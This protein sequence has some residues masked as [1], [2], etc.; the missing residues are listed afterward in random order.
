MLQQG[1]PGRGRL[2]AGPSAHQQGSAEGQF[3][4]ADAGRGRSQ[5]QVRPLR[6][7]RDAAG[8][9]DVPEQV[10]VRKIEAHWGYLLILR[11]QTT[12]KGYCNGLFSGSS[13]VNYEV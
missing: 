3:H 1:S 11:R 10:E 6:A 8:L 5:S 9:D 13:F 7:V 2:D 4:L 12:Q